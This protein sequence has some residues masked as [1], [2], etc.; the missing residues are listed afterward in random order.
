MSI[1]C[2][3]YFKPRTT[4]SCDVLHLNE[5]NYMVLCLD[6]QLGEMKKFLLFS[7]M[8]CQTCVLGALFGINQL[9]KLAFNAF[10]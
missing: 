7:L 2:V 4:F 5:R 9:V 1:N 3:V 6:G 8:F 10:N